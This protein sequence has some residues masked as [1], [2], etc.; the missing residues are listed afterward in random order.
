MPSSDTH[1]DSERLERKV[2]DL[3]DKLASA[4][5]TELEP[6]RGSRRLRGGDR[7][8]PSS[9][10]N[11]DL[12]AAVTFEH[13]LPASDAAAAPGARSPASGNGVAM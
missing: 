6:G 12:S 9:E 4:P 11:L 3:Y 1:T 5:E 8:G 2:A 13:L 7:A 10:L